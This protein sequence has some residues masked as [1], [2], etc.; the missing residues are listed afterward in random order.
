[1]LLLDGVAL[2][3][4]GRPV[5]APEELELRILEKTDLEFP[6]PA[7]GGLPGAVAEK[8]VPVSYTH[9]T[10]PTILLV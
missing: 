8:Y 6:A 10:L 9:L 5:L 7:F 3:S 2:T 1:M 4:S